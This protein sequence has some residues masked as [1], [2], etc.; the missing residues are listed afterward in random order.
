MLK[1]VFECAYRKIIDII[2][3]LFKPSDRVTFI[4]E[5]GF[6]SL[7]VIFQLLLMFS[8]VISSI[9]GKMFWILTCC[10]WI[11][12]SKQ[13][14][15]LSRNLSY[16]CIDKVVYFL[17]AKKI[18]KFINQICAVIRCYLH[19]MISLQQYNSTRRIKLSMLWSIQCFVCLEF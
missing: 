9:T 5:H 13:N 6:N 14:Y 12:A 7:M 16:K 11:P 17:D 15:K 3:M 1:N 18:V 2:D 19:Q 8:N 4:T 10:I